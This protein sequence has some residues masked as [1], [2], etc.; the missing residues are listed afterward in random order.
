MKKTNKHKNDG[1]RRWP[2]YSA[3]KP[4]VSDVSYELIVLYYELKIRCAQERVK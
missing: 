2:Y 4:Q 1:D 3:F